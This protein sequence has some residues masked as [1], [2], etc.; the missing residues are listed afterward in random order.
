[1][2][3]APYP[4]ALLSGADNNVMSSGHVPL[5]VLDPLLSE[6]TLRSV[7]VRSGGLGVDDDPGM[8][9]PSEQPF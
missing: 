7:A 2:L 6:E 8:S 1:M 9:L 4:T 5:V 3:P